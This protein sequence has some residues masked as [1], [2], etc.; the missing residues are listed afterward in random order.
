MRRLW[1]REFRLHPS[2]SKES[3]VNS[4]SVIR[5]FKTVRPRCPDGHMGPCN[6]PCWA[7]G[8]CTLA[9]QHN[10]SRQRRGL[11]NQHIISSPTPA[12]ALNCG[13]SGAATH[14]VHKGFRGAAPHSSG[15][16]LLRA[17]TYPTF[18]PRQLWVYQICPTV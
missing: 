9:H 4:T 8:I 17:K 1:L 12:P 14:F 7:C 15:G 11:S 10:L 13:P 6:P 18:L 2:Q 5:K 16:N 3:G